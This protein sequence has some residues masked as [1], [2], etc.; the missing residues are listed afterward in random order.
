MKNSKRIERAI[1]NLEKIK[2]LLDFYTNGHNPYNKEFQEI[3]KI[4]DELAIDK[5]VDHVRFAKHLKGIW[6]K[7][8]ADDKNS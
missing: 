1:H 8:E 7:N 2:D 4:I 6:K 3:S 5:K